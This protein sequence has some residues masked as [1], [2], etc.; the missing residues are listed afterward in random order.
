MQITAALAPNSSVPAA[1]RRKVAAEDMTPENWR[2]LISGLLEFFA[3]EAEEP[4]HADTEDEHTVGELELPGKDEKTPDLA[5]TDSALHLA[6][7]KD[8][9]R[10]AD[11]D[12]RIHVA[13]TNISKADVNPYRGKEIPGWKELGLDPD[14]IYDMLRAPEELEKA[15]KTF[16][17]IQF[18]TR[19]IP[20][21]ADDHKPYDVIGTTGTDAVFEDPYLKNS[22][23]IWVRDAIDDV[24]TEARKELSSGYHYKPDMTPGI[25]R[26]KPYAGVM[27]EIV[28]NHVALVKDGRAGDDV[29]V[30]DEQPEDLMKP[31]RIAAIAC[32]LTAKAIGPQLAMDQKVELMPIFKGVTSKNFDAKKLSAAVASAMKGKTLAQDVSIDH[33]TKMLDHVGEA[34]KA[35]AKSADESVSEPQHKAMEAAAH[36]HSTLDIPKKVGEEFADADKGKKSFDAEPLKGFLKEKGMSEDDISH[37]VSMLPE[38]QAGQDEEVDGEDEEE[39]D[40]D[41]EK[42]EAEAED[43]VDEGSLKAEDKAKDKDMVS[44]PAMDAAIKMAIKESNKTLSE[45]LQKQHRAVRDAERKVRPWVGDLAATM[46]F[47]SAEQVYEAA[48]KALGRDVKDVHPSAYPTILELIPKPGTQTEQSTRRS[49]MAMDSSG[50]DSLKKIVPDIDR[51]TVEA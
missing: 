32:R 22:L 5:A 24:E 40:D 48:F 18:L 44:K 20:V 23:V 3:E 45:T 8:S 42:K 28:G 47:D 2:D 33:V 34:A 26:G 25:F 19:H 49:S 35:D 17:G 27:R 41:E 1:A 10:E 4:E 21:S 36:G 15:A 13:I 46:S 38:N 12:G 31:T 6:F 51:I 16:N 14:E 50:M 30:G 7:D 9:V 39:D 11:R 29:C 37:I 43:K